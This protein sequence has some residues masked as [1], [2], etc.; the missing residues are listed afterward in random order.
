MPLAMAVTIF[1]VVVA[2]TTLVL[3]IIGALVFLW[4]ERGRIFP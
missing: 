4:Q 3:L 1:R 2:T